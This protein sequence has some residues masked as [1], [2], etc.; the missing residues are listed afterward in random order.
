MEVVEGEKRERGKGREVGQ[1]RK[2]GERW[3]EEEGR[4]GNNTV[5]RLTAHPEKVSCKVY[6]SQQM[7]FEATLY[8]V[9][10]H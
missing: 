9:P 10:Q 4:E 2:E 1:V 3:K 6:K 7:P 5:H 8:A